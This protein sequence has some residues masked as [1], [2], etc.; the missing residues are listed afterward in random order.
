MNN[1]KVF[2]T[3]K[4]LAQSLWFWALKPLGWR[5]L[6]CPTAFAV[7][8]ANKRM[9]CLRT[10]NKLNVQSDIMILFYNSAVA[11][12]L[13]YAG[14]TF[15]GMLNKQ[16]CALLGKPLR[17]CKKLLEA[18][19]HHRLNSNEDIYLSQLEKLAIKIMNDSSHPLNRNFVMLPSGRR[20]RM[21]R[22]RTNRF[23]NT[24]VP[25]AVKVLNS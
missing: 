4:N 6:Q 8:K 21:M 12:V 9:Y 23:K 15:Y 17:L 24:F 11:S 20:F 10:M 14:T 3:I 16:N 19:Y 13:M 1:P 2:I 7:R 18:N 5:K 22:A 25:K